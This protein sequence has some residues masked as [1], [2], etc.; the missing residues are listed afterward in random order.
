[1]RNLQMQ[2]LSEEWFLLRNRTITATDASVIMGVSPYST[3]EALWKR[4]LKI[5][6]P[7]AVNSSMTRGSELESIVRDIVE[8]LMEIKL[9]PAV[10]MA[11]DE[12]RIASLDGYSEAEGIAIEIKCPNKKFHAMAC[13][14]K[15]PESYFP[16]LQH[17]L[18]VI[19]APHMHYYSYYPG[20]KQELASVIVPRDEK[21]IELLRAKERVFYDCMINFRCPIS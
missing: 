9:E 14:G 13:A 21:Y 8:G 10:I 20:E 6:P 3:L 11:E 7:V 16:Q 18:D 5:Y 19:E 1:M 2:Q 4:K 12:Y 17:Q 15:V